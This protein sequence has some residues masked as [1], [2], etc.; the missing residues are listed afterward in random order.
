MEPCHTLSI[1]FAGI[2]VAMFRIFYGK[3]EEKD[4]EPGENNIPGQW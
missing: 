4:I 2:G 1:I 3:G